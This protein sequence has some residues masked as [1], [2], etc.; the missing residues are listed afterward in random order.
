[1][2]G[3]ADD[4]ATAVDDLVYG[5]AAEPDPVL[6]PLLYP[7]QFDVRHAI[8]GRLAVAHGGRRDG[9]RRLRAIAE[10]ARGIRSSCPG[11]EVECLMPMSAQARRSST[12]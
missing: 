6:E 5:D 4:A 7:R 9:H 11:S 1:M 12:E 3:K 10:S 8:V 2:G